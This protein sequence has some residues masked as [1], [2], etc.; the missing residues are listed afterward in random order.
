MDGKVNCVGACPL[1]GAL[2]QRGLNP[3]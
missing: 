1:Y 2:S 3:I